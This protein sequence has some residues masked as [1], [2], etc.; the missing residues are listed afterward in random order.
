MFTFGKMA[1]VTVSKNIV[2]GSYNLI[3]LH[4][5]EYYEQNK[6]NDP[7]KNFPANEVIQHI[8]IEDSADTIISD[9][10]IIYET[11]LK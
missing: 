6:Y 2:N 5:K 8:T 10:E 4:S 11:I 3:F 1:P 9:D 7:Y